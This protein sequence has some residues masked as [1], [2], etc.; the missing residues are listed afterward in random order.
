MLDARDP[1]SSRTP[2]VERYVRAAGADKK[3]VLLLNKI[4]AL[5]LLPLLL[6]FITCCTQLGI[7]SCT[8]RSR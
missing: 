6:L 5:L 4:G 2:D 7:N 1:L 8:L 3:L